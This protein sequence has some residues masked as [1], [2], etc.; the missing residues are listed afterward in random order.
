M[1]KDKHL[2]VD[3]MYVFFKT[4]LTKSIEGNIP[5]KMLIYKHRLQ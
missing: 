3:E 5:H 4:K 2:N 1:E